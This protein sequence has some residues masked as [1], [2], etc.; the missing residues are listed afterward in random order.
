MIPIYGIEYFGGGL[1]SV[2]NS[3]NTIQAFHQ[4]Q[5]MNAFEAFMLAVLQGSTIHDA[6][7]RDCIGEPDCMS[8]QH[9]IGEQDCIKDNGQVGTLMRD[10][11]QK[12]LCWTQRAAYRKICQAMQATSSA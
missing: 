4:A 11:C 12:Q 6:D 1:P 7:E 9:C 10:L 3:S 5:Q 2:N 8:E